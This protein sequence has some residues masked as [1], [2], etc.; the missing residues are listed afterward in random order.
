ML[1]KEMNSF[2]RVMSSLSFK[3]PDRV[4]LFLLLSTYGAKEMKV[5]V[6]EYFSKW[7]NIVDMQIKMKKKYNNDLVFT[8]FYAALEIEAMGGEVIF[9]PDGPPNSGEPILKSSKDIEEFEIPN[10]KNNIHLSKVLKATKALKSKLGDEVPIIG[11]VLSPFSLPVMQMG[12][13]KYLDLIYFN[14]NHFNLLMKKNEEFCVRWANAQIEAG[15]TAICYFDP[16]ASPNIIEPHTY[17]ETG[18]KVAKRA[19]KRING[20][21]AI[22]LASGIALPVIDEIIS[23]GTQV[24]GFSSSDDLDHIKRA[25]KDRICLLGNL[26][27]IEIVHWDKAKVEKEVKKLIKKAG[28]GGGLIISDNHGEIPLQVPERV[29]LEISEAVRE[30]GKYPLNNDTKELI[31]VKIN[32]R[33]VKNLN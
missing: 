27:G 29:L 31:T 10:I 18:H 25:S 6:K 7:E 30:Y 24:L 26:N 20:P 5:S 22:H 11:V 8:F 32:K 9:F 14:P 13:E 16:L 12:F 17:L 1:N 2:D 23:T 15:A 28:R 33:K 21:T 3:E 19:L 4:P